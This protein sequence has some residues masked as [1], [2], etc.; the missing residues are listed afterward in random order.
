MTAQGPWQPALRAAAAASWAPGQHEPPPAVTADQQLDLCGVRTDPTLSRRRQDPLTF[1]TCLVDPWWVFGTSTWAGPGGL[2]LLWPLTL[3]FPPHGPCPLHGTPLPPTHRLPAGRLV[4]PQ[5]HSI[6]AGCSLRWPPS[7]PPS[8]HC[9]FRLTFPHSI[10]GIAACLSPSHHLFTGTL[11]GSSTVVDCTFCAAGGRPT[12]TSL[13]RT[14]P[15]TYL[16]VNV[17]RHANVA[18]NALPACRPPPSTSSWCRTR[19]AGLAW[20][21]LWWGAGALVSPLPPRLMPDHDPAH[22]GPAPPPSAA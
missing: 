13:T 5:T 4:G 3:L 11:T 1:G 9:C 17:A 14:L 7:Q 19:V 20:L 12:L 18:L 15:H 10:H 16:R 6:S 21:H 2:Y 8:T 22:A